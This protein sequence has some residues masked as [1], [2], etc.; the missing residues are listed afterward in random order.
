MHRRGRHL[1][2]WLGSGAHTGEEWND[3]RERVRI[4]GNGGVVWFMASAKRFFL[5]AFGR[6]LKPI[7]SGI[8]V[9]WT[10]SSF[11]SKEDLIMLEDAN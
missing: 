1:V 9:R 5:G 11:R 4:L 6:S 10:E 7:Y 8:R 3:T 2:T